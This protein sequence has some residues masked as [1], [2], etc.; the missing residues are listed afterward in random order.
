MGEFARAFDDR[1]SFDFALRLFDSV[2]ERLSTGN[3]KSFPHDTPTGYQMHGK[4]M[5]LLETA[6]EL[7]DIAR[8]FGDPAADRLTEIARDS[9]QRTLT[10]FVKPEEKVLLE[11]IN[12]DGRPAYEEM[13]GSFYNPG[14][15]L[16]DAWFMMHFAGKTGDRKALETAVDVVRW[17]TTKGWDAE[18]GGLPQMLHKDGG[19]PRGEVAEENRGDHMLVELTENWDNKL[20]WVHSEALYAII[21]AYEH[22]RDRWFL[23]TYDR[24]HAYVFD[25]FPNPDESVGEWIQ[26][27]DRKGEPEEK[28]VALP[29]K[30]PYHVTRAFM[31]LIK[32]LKRIQEAG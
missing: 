9:M 8:F 14:H 30:D 7:A 20:W 18:Y 26:I 10:L 3:Y 29:V 31:H 13:L 32:S 2:Y 21:L 16:E 5:I 28:V 1:S 12:K 4:S 27:R 22:S 15:A 6:Q 17:M 24:Y 11:A 19:P 25:T 23:D